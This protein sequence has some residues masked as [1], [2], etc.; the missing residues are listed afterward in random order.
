MLFCPES[1]VLLE[2]VLEATCY[3]LLCYVPLKVIVDIPFSF[4]AVII[5]DY[6]D[7]PFNGILDWRKFAV[8]LRERDVYQLKQILKAITDEEFVRLHNNLVKVRHLF[9]FIY[10]LSGSNLK[11]F[12]VP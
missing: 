12:G 8:I 4:S 7:L 3:E 5:S 1:N 10:I 6:Y 11:T 2:F 9:C